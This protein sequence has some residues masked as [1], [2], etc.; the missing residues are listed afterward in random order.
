[1]ENPQWILLASC[2]QT[3]AQQDPQELYTES[4]FSTGQGKNGK[5]IIKK[6][7]AG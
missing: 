7:R 6:K 5:E 4:L 2:I 1:M 3:Q